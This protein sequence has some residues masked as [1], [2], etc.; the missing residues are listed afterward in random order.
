MRK[1]V[2]ALVVGLL[3]SSAAV[4]VMAAAPTQASCRHKKLKKPNY[5]VGKYKVHKFK[6]AKRRHR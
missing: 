4:P 1:I 2:W 6:K 5:K 3:L